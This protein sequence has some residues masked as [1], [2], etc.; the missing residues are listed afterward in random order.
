MTD[1]MPETDE[2]PAP[3][4]SWLWTVTVGAGALILGIGVLALFWFLRRPLAV[5]FLGVTLACAL[6][7]VVTWL[8]RWLPR[9]WATIVVYLVLALI[10]VGLGAIILPMLVDQA[11]QLID[12]A[13][14]YAEEARK[15][16]GERLG[17]RD[18]LPYEQ[19]LSQITDLAST[20]AALP[21]EISSSLVDAF[22][23][24]FISIYTLLLLPNARKTFLSLF[25][26]ERRDSIQEILR[27]AAYTM[28]GYFRGATIT[29]AVIGSV[30]YVGLLIIGIDFALVSAIIAGLAEFVPFIGP[31]IAGAII[32]IISFLQAPGKA[33]ISLIFVIALQQVEGNLVAPNVMHPQTC[34]SPLATLVALFAG[35]SV[36]GVLGALVAIP[37]Y[38]GLRVIVVEVIFPAIRRQ[39]GADPSDAGREC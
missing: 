32:V 13:P 22:L 17:L 27:R 21:V 2:Q 36:G 5:L 20:L 38:A 6:A 33:L 30:A 3:R 11:E 25:P 9:N 31:F 14:G 26:T 1:Q 15:W 4:G 18:G 8:E 29:G 10:L 19:M 28:G 24:V 23:V 39:S 7:P 35:W 37:L 16:M 34:I 12:Q